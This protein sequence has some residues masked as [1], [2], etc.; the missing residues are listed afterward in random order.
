MKLKVYERTA[1]ARQLLN[2]MYLQCINLKLKSCSY[3]VYNNCITAKGIIRIIKKCRLK[4]Y[5]PPWFLEVIN[6]EKYKRQT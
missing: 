2:Q 5:M 3:T 6:Y 1:L 4:S